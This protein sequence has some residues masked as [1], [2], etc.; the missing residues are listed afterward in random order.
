M[1]TDELNRIV[2]KLNDAKAIS[3]WHFRDAL[4]DIIEHY[5]VNNDT[6]FPFGDS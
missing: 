2:K 6:G 4:E 3:E 5:A 1:D